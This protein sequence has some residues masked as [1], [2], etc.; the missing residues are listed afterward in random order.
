MTTTHALVSRPGA[1]FTLD[2]LEVDDPRSDE[3]LVRILATGVCHSDLAVLGG[4]MMKWPGVLGHEGAG[5]VERI[6][7]GVTEFAVGDHVA[8]SVGWCG[9]CQACLSGRPTRCSR[10]VELNFTGTR[11]DGSTYLTAPGGTPVGGR[12]MGQSTFATYALLPADS[13]VHVLSDLD[14]VVV[15]ALGCGVQTGA[16]AV[17]NALRVQPG[18]SVVVSGAGSVGLG[19]VMA[20]RAAGATSVLA[21]DVLQ[22]R[23]DLALEVGATHAVDGTDR[24]VARRIGESLGGLADHAVDTTGRPEVVL[25]DLQALKADGALVAAAGG[26]DGATQGM[27]MTGKTIHNVILGDSV[28]RLFIPRLIRLHQRGMLPVDKLVT[29]YP[30]A[31][32]DSAVRDTRTGATTKA[33]LTT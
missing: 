22:S 9:R 28:P 15:A 23:L 16:G 4:P 32:I 25:A 33:V 17:I 20:A 10:M 8:T 27:A 7:S 2:E 21:V 5:V 6:G 14:P 29:T 19:A 13:L 12:F 31:D 1:D 18:D 3:V 11:P 26:V 24:E 30:L